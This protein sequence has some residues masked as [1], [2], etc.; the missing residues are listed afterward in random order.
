MELTSFCLFRHND[1]KTFLVWINEED[2]LRIISMQKGGNMKEV[3]SRFC[4]GLTQ[5]NIIGNEGTWTLPRDLSW[6][7]FLYNI[8]LKSADL[9]T[10][11]TLEQT[12]QD[13]VMIIVS[14][15]LFRQK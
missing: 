3:F 13:V 2:H 14:N 12:Y 11:Q 5:V 15:Y 6:F 8:Q 7:S 1:S 10:V 4:S 9:N